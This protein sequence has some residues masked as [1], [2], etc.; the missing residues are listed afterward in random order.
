M[1]T[2]SRLKLVKAA[3]P[4]TFEVSNCA[5]KGWNGCP[6]CDDRV[7]AD[8]ES[9][10]QRGLRELL[11]NGLLNSVQLPPMARIIYSTAVSEEY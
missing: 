9:Y 10:C 2:S 8:G 11:E 4:K 7:R 1:I 5:K 3:A 6:T